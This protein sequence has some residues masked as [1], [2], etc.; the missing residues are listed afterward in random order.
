LLISLRLVYIEEDGPKSHFYSFMI[1]AK[2]L[3]S[4]PRV[5]FSALFCFGL[6]SALYGPYAAT[7]LIGVVWICSEISGNYA[8]YKLGGVMGDYRK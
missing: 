4:L 1:R 2:F 8:R 6:A 5:I 3:V 7:A